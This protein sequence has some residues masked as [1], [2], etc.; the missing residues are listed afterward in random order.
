[1]SPDVVSKKF[2]KSYFELIL[3][4]EYVHR[5]MLHTLRGGPSKWA[6]LLV[7][8]IWCTQ[9][10]GWLGFKAVCAGIDIKC[11]RGQWALNV[12]GWLL[13]TIMGLSCGI[14]FYPA[15]Q[16]SAAG[17]FSRHFFN[18]Y[19]SHLYNV[20]MLVCGTVSRDKIIVVWLLWVVK[21]SATTCQY[22][23]VQ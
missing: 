12:E 16:L 19:V 5:W 18:F 7:S 13:F 10:L 22:F 8:Y 15:S 20:H 21:Y 4:A 6:P 23:F 2:W 17:E 14:V 3:L 1:M 9:R 11:G